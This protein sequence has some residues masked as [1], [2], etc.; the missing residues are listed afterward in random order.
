MWAALRRLGPCGHP[1]RRGFCASGQN[2]TRR[3]DGAPVSEVQQLVEQMKPKTFHDVVPY[4]SPVMWALISVVVG[5]AY[6]N[7]RCDWAAQAEN[8][9]M[10]EERLARRQQA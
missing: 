9:R 10:K 3:P 4:K 7:A 1:G 2:Q 8:A 5:L 6:Y